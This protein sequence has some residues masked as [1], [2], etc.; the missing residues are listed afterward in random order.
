M[1][2]SH[3]DREQVI[4]VLKTAFVQGQLAKDELDLRVGQ[5]LASRTYADLGALTA[6]IPA[7]PVRAQSPTP[8]GKPASVP[9]PTA[10]RAAI[11]LMCAGAVLTLAD[12]VTVLVTLGGV[13]WAAAHDIGAGQW[14][15]VMLTQA[16]FWLASAPIGAGVWLW[17]AWANGQGYHWARPAFAAFFGLLTIVPLFGLGGDAL[18]YT[19]R[20]VIATTVLWLVGLAAMLLL[21]SETAR[22]YS[23][24][25][26]ATPANG[27]GR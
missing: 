3:A 24:R 2:A 4:D 14:P 20:D 9:K 13:R 8:A 6:D 1:R 19:W 11:G 7:G 26:A 22:S 10:V 27:T 5:V 21:F 18:P 25:R 12:V 17:L 23:Q 16:D 15:I